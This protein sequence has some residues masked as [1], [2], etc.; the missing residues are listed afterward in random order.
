M[1]LVC[2]RA[3]VCMRG[4]DRE[5]QGETE[6]QRDRETDKQAD[7]QTGRQRKEKAPFKVRTYRIASLCCLLTPLALVCSLIFA[8]QT[9]CY[10]VHDCTATDVDN[11]EC[12]AVTNC[13]KTP[14]P[15]YVEV[16]AVCVHV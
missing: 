4:R 5:R 16:C 14:F 2:V 8:K 11:D 9:A 13:T 7:R 12:Y 15:A 10:S 3:C 6:R 1:S